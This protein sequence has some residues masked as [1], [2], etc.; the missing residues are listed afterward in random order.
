[1]GLMR[2]ILLWGSQNAYLRDTLPRY[3]FVRRAVRRFMPGEELD[4]ALRA[5]EELRDK[6]I[7]TTLT[8]LGENVTSTEEANAVRDHY[9]EV[10]DQVHERG[11]D[12]HLSTKLTQLGLDQHPD[13][14]YDNMRAITRKAIQLGN[15]TWVDME[16]SPYVDVTIEIYRRIRAE[17]P[18]I[19]ICL[20]SY[21]R[22]TPGDLEPLY[23]L[24]P[25]IRLVKGAYKES[26]EVAFPKKS[27]VDESFFQISSAYL[28]RIGPNKANLGYATH[29]LKL[30]RRIAAE[31]ERQGIGKQAPEYQML[32]GIQSA[33]QYRLAREG[34]KVRVLIAYG[35]YWFPWYMRRLAERPANVW[36][37]LK[38]LV[39]S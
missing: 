37:V 10:L 5:A 23:P 38:N 25:A 14:A 6:G 1:M 21:L 22:R 33:E 34:H 12:T 7:G 27:D 26:P 28:K 30:I 19:G 2:S 15:F 13:L 3:R 36:F 29:D 39:S 11:L 8:Q 9:L 17:L 31:A 35:N 32:Y 4:A 16:S 20:Q 24:D 18:N